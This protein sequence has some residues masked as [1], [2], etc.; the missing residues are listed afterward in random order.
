MSLL[1]YVW[2]NLDKIAKNYTMSCMSNALM[3][4]DIRLVGYEVLNLEH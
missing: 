3:D 1:V 2:W 4:A